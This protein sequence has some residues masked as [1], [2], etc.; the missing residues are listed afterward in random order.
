MGILFQALK[1]T[2]YMIFPFFCGQ[3]VFD[4]GQVDIARFDV[5]Q[6][7]RRR[8]DEGDFRGVEDFF[9]RDAEALDGEGLFGRDPFADVVEDFVGQEKFKADGQV[10]EEF[11][12]CIEGRAVA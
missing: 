2:F 7:R 9:P 10:E 8:H 3:A 12:R 1:D 11:R 6:E 5:A 4:I